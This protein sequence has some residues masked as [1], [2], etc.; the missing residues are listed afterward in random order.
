LRILTLSRVQSPEG[1]ETGDVEIRVKWPYEQYPVV[2][3]LG[4][5]TY[6][7]SF[8]GRGTARF[9]VE[10]KARTVLQRNEFEWIPVFSNAQASLLTAEKGAM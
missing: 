10:R 7:G 6:T 1:K 3:A 4:R 8:K 5:V 9:I 2:E